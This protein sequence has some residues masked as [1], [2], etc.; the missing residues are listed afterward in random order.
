MTIFLG[1]KA[2]A[3][4]VVNDIRRATGKHHSALCAEIRGAIL[5]TSPFLS[6]AGKELS[7]SRPAA[8]QSAR[9]YSPPSISVTPSRPRMLSHSPREQW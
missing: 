2:P 8:A 1:S 7:V 9:P 6:V 4:R 5:R 3:D